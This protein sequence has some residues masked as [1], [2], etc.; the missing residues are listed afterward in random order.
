MIC[1]FMAV[2]YV[3]QNKE[4]DKLQGCQL[5]GWIAELVE[6]Q[7]GNPEGSSPT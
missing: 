6:H 7:Y 3:P 4:T 5:E 2:D 1:S